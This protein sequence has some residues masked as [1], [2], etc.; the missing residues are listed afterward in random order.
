MKLIN[1]ESGP[2]HQE[3]STISWNDLKI[4]NASYLN[5]RQLQSNL[6]L[7][8]IERDEFYRKL[9]DI[10]EKTIH[11]TP[12]TMVQVMI[13]HIRKYQYLLFLIRFGFGCV[14]YILDASS[15]TTG[16]GDPF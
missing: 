5:L 14:S 10:P 4:D 13:S 9:S 12:K 8:V 3:S 11:S 16:V 6:G 7:T 1:N 15:V 2:I